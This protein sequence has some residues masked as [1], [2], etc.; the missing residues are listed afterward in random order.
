MRI[1]ELNSRR[2]RRLAMVLAATAAVLVGACGRS[3]ERS[4]DRDS[5]ET[6]ES[7]AVRQSATSADMAVPASVDAVGHHS[8]N[9]Y[10][11]A[12]TGAWTAARA[13][14]DSLSTAVNALPAAGDPTEKVR[15]AL[16]RLDQAVARQDQRASAVAANQLTALGAQLV[17]AYNPR[18]PSD[19]VLLDYYGRELEIW[20]GAGDLSQLQLTRDALQRTW[21]NV[22][23]LVEQRGGNAESSRF[24]QLVQKIQTARTVAEFGAL[25]T[26][27]LDE[28]DSLE[29]VFAR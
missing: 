18:V 11:M 4:D 15:E 8:E 16:Q 28:V 5:D 19:V 9:A 12:K 24:Q 7:S 23:P 10:D 14:V 17:S 6:G 26:P 3:A 25:A 2:S 29:A 13:S 21:A 1:S 27:I 22:R 20:A